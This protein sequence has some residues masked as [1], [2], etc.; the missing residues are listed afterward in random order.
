MGSALTSYPATIP[1]LLTGFL[2]SPTLWLHPWLVAYGAVSP[3]ICLGHRPVATWRGAP[4]S[5]APPERAL[6]PRACTPTQAWP[7]HPSPRPGCPGLGPRFNGAGTVVAF[8]SHLLDHGFVANCLCRVRVGVWRQCYPV[9]KA[10]SPH[11]CDSSVGLLCLA[12]PCVLALAGLG[13][14]GRS[15]VNNPAASSSTTPGQGKSAAGSLPRADKPNQRR[16]VGVGTAHAESSLAPGIEI[17][18]AVRL[19][20][21]TPLYW[22]LRCPADDWDPGVGAGR[23]NGSR[24]QRRWRSARERA[25]HQ[26]SKPRLILR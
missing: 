3:I 17:V 9:A 15:W 8:H 13:R 2:A 16:C 4:A 24:R 7:G 1:V 10:C 19:Y 22:I 5:L 20:R 21:L 12:L 11:G 18:F 14:F 6:A 25:T 23:S 26:A